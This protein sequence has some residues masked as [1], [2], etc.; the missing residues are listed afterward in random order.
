MLEW[1]G[2]PFIGCGMDY[3]KK[4]LFIRRQLRKGIPCAIVATDNQRVMFTCL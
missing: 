3:K 4:G 2:A 1:Q